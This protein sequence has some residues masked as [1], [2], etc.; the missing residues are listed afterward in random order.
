MVVNPHNLS[1]WEEGR[2]EDQKSTRSCLKNTTQTPPPPPEHW[3]CQNLS[4]MK[5]YTCILNNYEAEAERS[6][7][8]QGQPGFHSEHQAARGIQYDCLEQ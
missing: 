4:G 6:L 8:V 5:A 3:V 1:A 2:Q 7:Q